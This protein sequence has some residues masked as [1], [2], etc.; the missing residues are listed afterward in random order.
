MTASTIPTIAGVNASEITEKPSP[1][2][3]TRQAATRCR[4]WRP[5]RSI[6]RAQTIITTAAIRYGKPDRRPTATFD[7]PCPFKI[8]GSQIAI[9]LMPIQ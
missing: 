4:Q 3:A 9:P 5:E 2:A 6:Q 8:N 1:A 7:K